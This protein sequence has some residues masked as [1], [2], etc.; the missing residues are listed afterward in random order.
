MANQRS[1]PIPLIGPIEVDQQS[2]TTR[3]AG[4]LRKPPI[5]G[6]PSLPDVS[7]L[8]VQI[9]LLLFFFALFLSPDVIPDHGLI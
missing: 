7:T 5:K 3:I 4:S 2:G 8:K 9:H 1:Q 6:A